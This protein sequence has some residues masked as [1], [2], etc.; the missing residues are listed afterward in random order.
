MVVDINRINTVC[1]RMR[2]LSNRSN[3]LNMP[4]SAADVTNICEGLL[5]I[6]KDIEQE[7]LV[8]SNQLMDIKNNLFR[9]VLVNWNTIC[10]Y[11][12]PFAFGKGIEVLDILLAQN[13]NRQSDWWQL[14]HPRIAQVSKKLFLD[15]SYANA[16][17]DAYI[18]IN[19]RVKRLFRAIKPEEKVP[20]GDAAMKTVFSANAPLIEFCDRS[21]DSGSNTQ[22]GFMEMLAGAMSAL[23]NPKAHANITISQDDAMRRLIFASMLMYKIDEAVLYTKIAEPS[24]TL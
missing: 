3:A 12:N 18:E 15:G 10:I 4:V 7:Q 20:D 11:I 22:K 13:F 5:L 2:N 16:A 19:D 24:K 9:E 6:A 23:R 17:C 21:T 1:C 8:L 14:I